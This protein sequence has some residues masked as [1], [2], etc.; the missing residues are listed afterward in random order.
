MA[1]G[2]SPVYD[3]LPSLR[4]RVDDFCIGAA[5]DEPLKNLKIAADRLRIT[6][7]NGGLSQPA[8]AHFLRMMA[9]WPDALTKRTPPVWAL[10]IQ[11]LTVRR[12]AE[13]AAVGASADTLDHSYSEQVH[14][15][16]RPQIEA[17]DRQR[18]LGEDL[19]FSSGEAARKRS[20]QALDDARKLY[21][22]ALRR[23]E[24]VRPPSP[25]GTDPWPSCPSTRDGLHIAIPRCSTTP[26]PGPS[27]SL[28]KTHAMASRL[29]KPQAD[30]DLG[31]LAQA[32]KTLSDRRDAVAR[33]LVGQVDRIDVAR[34]EGGLLAGGATAAAAVPF[35]DSRDLALR[36][37]LSARLDNIRGHD[38]DPASGDANSAPPSGQDRA[39]QAR[40]AR[41]RGQIQGLMAL[42]ALGARWFD[43]EETKAR[44]EGD[45][46]AR[47]ER[48]RRVSEVATERA[49]AWR[50]SWTRPAAWSAIVG[51]R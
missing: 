8:E 26:C 22:D 11:A 6:S 24:I 1:A 14:P 44:G 48:V 20:G 50:K 41:R 9:N 46:E 36:E 12:L 51:N 4:I 15:W 3:P 10:A 18:R 30:G 25:P 5:M 43:D 37:R 32:A 39:H 34:I 47:V 35:A 42:S 27:R 16:I 17:A 13:R 31:W 29:E 38:R 7:R 28:E 45:F 21:Q 49:G 19:F 23:A 33:G 40:Y 2:D